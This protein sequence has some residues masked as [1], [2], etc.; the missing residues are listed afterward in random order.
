M[1]AAHVGIRKIKKLQEMKLDVEIEI[2]WR[3]VKQFDEFNFL[4]IDQL[5][6]KI[7]AKS[8]RC[9]LWR[10]VGTN[11]MSVGQKRRD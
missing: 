11:S 8:E 7:T 9:G 4:R 6:D 3:L 10:R 2:Q 5:M 1:L